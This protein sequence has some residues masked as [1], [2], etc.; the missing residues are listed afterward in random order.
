VQRDGIEQHFKYKFKYIVL[1]L[2][3]G[4]LYP[5]THPNTVEQPW[6]ELLRNFKG[7]KPH[8]SSDSLLTTYNY[9]LYLLCV[10]IASCFRMHIIQ[11]TMH[12]SVYPHSTQSM[13]VTLS[14]YTRDTSHFRKTSSRLN[15][16]LNEYLW[17]YLDIKQNIPNGNTY[18]A[19][20]INIFY[21]INRHRGHQNTATQFSE[22]FM[23]YK[24]FRNLQYVSYY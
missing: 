10:S 2:W 4:R 7:K 18:H 24:L 12:V 5:L 14:Q 15:K 8:G 19:Y 16:I 3:G 22:L 20:M 1:L 17:M 6:N 21:G 11:D 13:H 9:C 23:T